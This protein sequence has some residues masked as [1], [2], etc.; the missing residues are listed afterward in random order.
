MLNYLLGNSVDDFWFTKSLQPQKHYVIMS[1]RVTKEKQF[2]VRGVLF[3]MRSSLVFPV[4]HHRQRGNPFRFSKLCQHHFS[5]L[6]ELKPCRK[7]FVP[8]ALLFLIDHR[9]LYS[10][11]A[12]GL[13]KRPSMSA[14]TEQYSSTG[15]SNFIYHSASQLF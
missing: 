13:D 10:N 7:T 1:L 2:F 4:P 6:A 11:R 12:F 3:Q 5:L 14:D 8:E 9:D 15:A